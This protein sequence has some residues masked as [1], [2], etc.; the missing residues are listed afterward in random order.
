MGTCASTGGSSDQE[1][2]ASRAIDKKMREERKNIDANLKL[3]LL[4]AGE[5]GKSTIFKQMKILHQK[6]YNQDELTAARPQVH[7]NAIQSMKIL[8]RNA[9]IFE[10]DLS[11]V[12]NAKEVVLDYPDDEPLVP[13]LVASIDQLWKCEAIQNTMKRSNQ[14]HIPDCATYFL[15]ALHRISAPNFVPTQQD[16]LMVRV[17]TTSVVQ[18]EFEIQGVK[19][20]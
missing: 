16:V 7:K 8:I 9:E 17:M 4:G 13:S 2:Q 1:F 20:R 14:F 18:T 10:Y 15:N 12:A 5:S 19:F 6:G 3:L 11:S